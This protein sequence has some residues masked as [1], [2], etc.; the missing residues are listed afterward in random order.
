MG[1]RKLIVGVFGTANTGKTTLIDDIVSRSAKEREEEA[2]W[3]LFGKDYREVIKEKG[4][5]INRDGD[6]RSQ[7]VIHETL[8]QNIRDAVMEN[9]ERRLIMDRTILDSFA[10]TYYLKMFG[11][12]SISDDLIQ[13]MWT[14]V[15]LYSPCFDSL[16]YIPLSKCGDITVEDD[17]F[18]DTN[19]EYRKRIDQIFSALFVTLV[20]SGRANMD[21]IFGT[22][23]KRIKWFLD[24]K[25]Y[26]MLHGNGE[27]Q[28]NL[29]TFE[30]QLE[31]IVE[32]N[33]QV[34]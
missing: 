21:I 2:R 8:L 4:L 32:G 33:F 20:L 34:I 7:M 1:N 24:T 10:Y 6:E 27:K 28:A 23:E 13:K 17:K 16:L 25:E 3:H 19:F 31:K 18:R 11:E 15:E 9:S 29:D 30:T 5:V 12:K 22:R 26:L 14:D